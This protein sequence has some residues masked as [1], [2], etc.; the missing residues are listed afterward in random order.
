MPAPVTLL[1]TLYAH[2]AWANDKILKSCAGLSDAQLD[3]TRELGFGSLRNTL[4]HIL[5]AEEIWLERWEGRTWRPFETSAAGAS[6]AEIAL[7]LESVATARAV[8]LDRER[9]DGWRRVVEYKNAQ[10]AAFR[11]PLADLLW[12][13]ANHGIHHRAQALNYLR[14]FDRKI[15]GGV[16]YVFYRLAYPVLEQDAA[17]AEGFRAYGLEMSSG[18]GRDL[19]W[20][21]SFVRRY[22]TYAD[23]AND[24]LLDATLDLSDEELDR[25][26][27]MGWD[28]LRKT[29]THILDAEAWWLRNWTIG[30]AAFEKLDSTTTL[31]RLR[32]EWRRVRGER[33]RFVESLDDA[34]AARVVTALVG[35]APVRISVVESLL[36]LCGHGTH[37]RAQWIN[38]LR[39]SQVTPP[40]VDVIVWL[41]R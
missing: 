41:R 39:A 6:L 32:E 26:R 38:M 34:G 20:D 12:H 13:V 31:A 40:G 28:T 14:L 11:N 7:R 16:D 19:T 17:V 1:E 33:D 10:G 5:A 22:F 23:W 24:Q 36:Q 21:A 18:P 4:F 27:S 15:P 30:P 29:M 25:P 9:A 2:D 3:Q 8:L 37:H 35:A